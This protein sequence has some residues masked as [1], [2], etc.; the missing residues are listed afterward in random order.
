MRALLE[1]LR[2]RLGE[3]E[4]RVSRM[5]AEAESAAVEEEEEEERQQLAQASKALVA[6]KETHDKAVEALPEET[7]P[8][9][10]SYSAKVLFFLIFV[11]WILSGGLLPRSGFVAVLSCLP[12][13]FSYY[14]VCCSLLG[15]RAVS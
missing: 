1:D 4:A 5:E 12:F 6:G 14:I 15:Q 2:R 11:A 9:C 8:R 7:V 10:F 3:A 13:P